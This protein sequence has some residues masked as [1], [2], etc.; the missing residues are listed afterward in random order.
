MKKILAKLLLL[1]V[2]IAGSQQLI[3]Q[4][5]PPPGEHGEPGNQNA[6]NAPIDGG[7][8]VLLVLGAAY[9]SKRLYDM[10]KERL[11]D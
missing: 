7:L 4:P 10:R 11:E 8:G 3:S 5:P 6:G 9:G 2:L 1:T